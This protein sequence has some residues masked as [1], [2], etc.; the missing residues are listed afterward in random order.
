MVVVAMTALGNIRQRRWER[1]MDFVIYSKHGG[2]RFKVYCIWIYL[3][4]SIRRLLV[5]YIGGLFNPLS[6]SFPF[7]D[8]FALIAWPFRDGLRCGSFIHK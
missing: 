8:I 3:C 7:L 5:C 6:R 4:L 1:C 2:D